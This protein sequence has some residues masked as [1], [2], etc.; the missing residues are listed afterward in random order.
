MW[1]KLTEWN[2]RT[3]VKLIKDSH[4]L[5]R[6][7][8]TPGIKV[9]NLV[10]ASDEMVWASWSFVDEDVPN[11]RHMNEVVGAYV[12]A[13][14]RLHLYSYVDKLQQCAISFQTSKNMSEEVPQEIDAVCT[15]II[16]PEVTDIINH[17]NI[18][19]RIVNTG[20]KLLRFGYA[21]KNRKRLRQGLP[22]VLMKIVHQERVVE[23]G[24]VVYKVEV[25]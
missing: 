25:L 20:G 9:A 2:N 14:A 23:N 22:R 1:G 19:I 4:E 3:K 12:T 17:E 5:Y 7:L 10:F 21:I 11:L 15:N 16:G 24:T 8:A 13:G 6:F 18:K